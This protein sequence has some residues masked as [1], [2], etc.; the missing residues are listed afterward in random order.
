MDDLGVLEVHHGQYVWLRPCWTC[1]APWISNFPL[2]SQPSHLSDGGAGDVIAF[3]PCPQSQ[4]WSNL[5]TASQLIP[6]LSTRSWAVSTL[7]SFF[8]SSALLSELQD[9]TKLASPSRSLK[10]WLYQP[11]SLQ[12]FPLVEPEPLNFLQASGRLTIAHTI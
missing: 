2:W 7:T 4:A 6:S 12:W 9:L 1:K 8:L 10:S 3:W 5:A 11:H